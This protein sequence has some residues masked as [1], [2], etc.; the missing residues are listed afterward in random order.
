MRNVKMGARY[1]LRLQ[2]GSRISSH[3]R[4]RLLARFL[5]L[6]LQFR[7][8]LAILPMTIILA[9]PMHLLAIA[10]AVTDGAA[11]TAKLALLA[12]EHGATSTARVPN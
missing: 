11:S 10:A 2:R 9:V 1:L 6:P 7:R 5:E 3:A 4:G 8:G 12:L